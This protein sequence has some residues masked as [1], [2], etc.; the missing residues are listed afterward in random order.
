MHHLTF[1]AP[2]I[3]APALCIA[4]CELVGGYKEQAIVAASAIHLMHAA[5]Y[6]HE[7]LPLTDGDKPKTKHLF[8]PNIELLTSDGIIPFGVELLAQMNDPFQTN[9]QRILRVIVEI[10]RAIGSQG[11]IEGQYNMSQHSQSSGEEAYHVSIIDKVCKKKEGELHAC[12]AA[13]GAILGGGSEEEIETLRRYGQYV[14]TIQG[15]LNLVEKDEKWR[16]L[17]K[18]INELRDLALNELKDFHHG[19]VEA[20]SSF[21]EAKF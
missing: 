18:E 10:T 16:V 19:K 11:M 8:G 6:A 17:I 3:T 9:S 15:I 1:T 20:I 21:V 4:A 5:S 2:E 12:A 14:G 7:Q 13:C